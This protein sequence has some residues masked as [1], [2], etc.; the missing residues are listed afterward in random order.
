MTHVRKL[1]RRAWSPK[2][3]SSILERLEPR[4]RLYETRGHLSGNWIGE[5][6]RPSTSEKKAVLE[7]RRLPF[8]ME[9]TNRAS[10][11]ELEQ[12]VPVGEICRW[13]K[14]NKY[15]W[16]WIISVMDYHRSYLF[17]LKNSWS[18]IMM[19][20]ETLYVIF[21]FQNH[22][23]A[24]PCRVLSSSHCCSDFLPHFRLSLF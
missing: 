19:L 14:M 1:I 18:L 9:K 13:S 23:E 7:T 20:E 11:T 4:K 21:D 10:L 24:N 17:I 3:K 6:D 2:R 16:N 8:K 12:K 22:C 5:N 15:G